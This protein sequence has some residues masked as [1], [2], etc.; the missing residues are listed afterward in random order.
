MKLP[1]MVIVLASGGIFTGC[2]SSSFT[3]PMASIQQEAPLECRLPCPMPP[4][5]G[6]PRE[7]WDAA[8]FSWGA[9]CAQLHN[10]CVSA[11]GS[12]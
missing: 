3:Q 1:A 7:M 6:L 5:T 9:D 4:S 10:D 11:V 12:K 8:V 2:A